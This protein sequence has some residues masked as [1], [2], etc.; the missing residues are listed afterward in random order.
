VTWVAPTIRAISVQARPSIAQAEDRLE[1]RREGLEAAWTSRA[2][3]A[4][5]SDEEGAARLVGEVEVAV[6]L[7]RRGRR[8]RRASLRVVDREIRDDPI[9]PGREPCEKSKLERLRN[10]RRKASW[11]RSCASSSLPTNPR[12]TRQA[13]PPVAFDE[14]GEGALVAHLRA[15]DQRVVLG[16]GAPPPRRRVRSR[17]G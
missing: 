1:V 14:L 10:T 11:T 5:S 4:R 3:S 15:P 7:R 16:P 9:E 6:V 8:D 12:A 13:A 2:R 17:R